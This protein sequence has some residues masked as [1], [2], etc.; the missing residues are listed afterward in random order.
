MS[1]THLHYKGYI[2]RLLDERGAMWDYEV[3]D[4]AMKDYG[5]SGE[6][7]YGTIRLTLIDL[8]SCGLVDEIENSVDPKK[9]FGRE[10]VLF[11]FQLNDFGRRRLRQAKLT[12]EKENV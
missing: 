11:K 12:E 8:F 3:T 9:S 4:Q 2:M 5:L 6:Y 7:W 10:K 1:S